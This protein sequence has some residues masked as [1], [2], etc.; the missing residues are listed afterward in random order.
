MKS[1]IIYGKWYNVESC[2]HC[3]K[4]LTNTEKMYSNGRCPYC[5][6]KGGSAGTIVNTNEHAA[7]S[8]Y[9]KGYW[10]GFIPYWKYIKTE[11]KP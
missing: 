1:E 5:G 3:D 10:L 11:T 2:K 4:V 7:R 9:E 6:V 8:V